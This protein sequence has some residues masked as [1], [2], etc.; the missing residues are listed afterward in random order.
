MLPTFHDGL[1]TGL[2]V[3]ERTGTISIRRSDGAHWRIELSGVIALK[4]DGFREGN[5]VSHL[6][7][8]CGSRPQR[9]W[10]EA[11]LPAPD[12]GAASE[13]HEKHRSV[14]EEMMDRVARGSLKLV[15]VVSSYGCDFLALCEGVA[16]TELA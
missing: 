3:A 14:V 7:V 15:S 10:I 6:E 5:I 12:A 9:Q 8:V 16:A 11:L 1:L 13:Y 4:A 2:A